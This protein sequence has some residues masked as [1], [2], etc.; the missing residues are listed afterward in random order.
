MNILFIGNSYTSRNDLEKLFEALCRENGFQVQAFRVS[1][2]G[3]R[4]IRYT[5][6]TDP[7]TQLLRQT[8]QAR[9]YDAVFL[10]EQSLQ[11]LLD[12]DAFAAGMQYVADLV[13]P[14]SSKL[15]AYATWA[16]KAGSPD[17][18]IHG[19]TPE[20]MTADLD[21]AYRTVAQTVGAAVS[22]VGLSFR[23]AM[24]LDPQLELY[25]PDLYHPSYL[26]S[27]LAALTHYHTLFGAFPGN[28]RSLCLDEPVRAVFEAAVCRRGAGRG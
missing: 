5:C 27:C 16:R 3:R 4:M 26:G 10:Q 28:I 20:T 17:L 19:W 21:A 18:A 7:V 12:F 22:S 8:L 25:D 13:K 14:H 15:I 23:A 9:H 24:E 2:G 1:E 11:P 6:D